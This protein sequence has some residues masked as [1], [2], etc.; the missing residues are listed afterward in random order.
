V[1]G[2]HVYTCRSSYPLVG[3][4]GSTHT[5]ID[6]TTHQVSPCP[7]P[8]PI[9][10]R[11]CRGIHTYTH[12]HKATLQTGTQP[13]SS[14]VVWVPWPYIHIHICVYMYVC[15]PDNARLVYYCSSLVGG[16]DPPCPWGPVAAL[17]PFIIHIESSTNLL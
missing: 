10:G 12:T 16:C 14:C 4:P 17:G 5:C 15:A 1:Q 8:P 3:V 2:G 6:T 11:D 13:I 7:H 9:I